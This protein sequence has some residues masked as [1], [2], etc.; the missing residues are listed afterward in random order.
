MIDR[1]RAARARFGSSLLPTRSTSHAHL[2]VELPPELTAGT[3]E[4]ELPDG[5][6]TAIELVP[7]DMPA[8]GSNGS[9][10]RWAT[11]AAEETP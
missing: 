5:R 2:D 1:D 9:T 10:D 3:L 11:P 7:E 6:I 8:S 4:I